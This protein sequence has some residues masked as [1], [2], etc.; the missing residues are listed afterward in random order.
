MEEKPRARMP[1]LH[2][3]YQT[4]AA[5]GVE[6]PGNELAPHDIMALR[7]LKA[8]KTAARSSMTEA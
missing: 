1:G 4:C 7:A 6:A 5:G 3:S 8:T 2:R